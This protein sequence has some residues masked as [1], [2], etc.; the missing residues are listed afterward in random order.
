MHIL[1]K[2]QIGRGQQSRFP[3]KITDWLD[4]YTYTYISQKYTFK[5][6]G[7]DNNCSKSSDPFNYTWKAIEI[8]IF[9]ADN[10]RSKS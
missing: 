5:S 4:S 3:K 7:A 2:F 1:R 9:G 10:N 6:F 8:E